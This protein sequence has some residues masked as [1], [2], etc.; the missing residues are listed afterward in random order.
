MRAATSDRFGA[1]RDTNRRLFTYHDVSRRPSAGGRRR[2]RLKRGS[3]MHTMAPLA[4]DN[5]PR[6]LPGQDAKRPRVDETPRGAR[7]AVR[8]RD[9]QDARARSAVRGEP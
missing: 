2:G 3:A 7:V 6:S 9:G 4:D 5:A 1:L 8:L